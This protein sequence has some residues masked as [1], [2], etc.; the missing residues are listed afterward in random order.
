MNQNKLIKF[1]SLL[2]K[3]MFY[4]GIPIVLSLPFSLRWSGDYFRLFRP[5]YYVLMLIVLLFAGVFALL[6]LHQLN[7]MI[8]TVIEHNSFVLQNVVSLKRMGLYSFILSFIFL[9][10]ITFRMTPATLIIIPTFFIA[11]L[12]C[13]VLAFVFREAIQYKEENELTI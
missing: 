5:E 3:L 12:F 2:L 4:L 13:F 10:K 1:T 7:K 8:K 9:I 6:I 11:G